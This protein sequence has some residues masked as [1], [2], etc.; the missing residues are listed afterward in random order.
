MKSKIA[1]LSAALAVALALTASF[2][3]SAFAW[4][5]F[6]PVNNRV[7]A[8]RDINNNGF[9][10]PYDRAVLGTRHLYRTV[11][12]G[13]RVNT[14]LENRYDHNNNGWI[15]PREHYA[16]THRNVSNWRD[17]ACDANHNGIIGPGEVR[18]AY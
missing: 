17:V 2:S 5:R 13:P 7:E 9:V 3:A 1:K 4:Q 10:G 8:R 14:P 12:A 11:S 6:N 18:C 15:G 16:I